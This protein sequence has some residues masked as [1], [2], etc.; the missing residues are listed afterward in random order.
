MM[1]VTLLDT[2]FVTL[3]TASPWPIKRCEY[4]FS[5]TYARIIN[6][7]AS[8]NSIFQ[9]HVIRTIKLSMIYAHHL[10]IFHHKA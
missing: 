1:V 6:D 7:K 10:K 9:R 5:Y 2:I 4:A 3:L 8:E